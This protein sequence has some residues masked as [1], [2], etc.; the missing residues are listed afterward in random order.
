MSVHMGVGDGI[1]ETPAEG[2]EFANVSFPLMSV[3]V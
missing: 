3:F 1:V 2:T